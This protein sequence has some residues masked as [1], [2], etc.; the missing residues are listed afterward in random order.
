MVDMLWRFLLSNVIDRTALNARY[1]FALDFTPDDTTP[2][3][4]GPGRAGLTERP[5]TFKSNATIF[6]ALEQQLGL[7]LEPTKAP[8]EYIVIDHAERPRPNDPAADA[9]PSARAGGPG[10]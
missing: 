7:H 2:G 10:K 1:T 5:T 3:V 6:Q 4:Q 8:S 9:L